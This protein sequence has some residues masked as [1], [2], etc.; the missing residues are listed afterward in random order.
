[1]A[2]DCS[3]KKP[4]AVLLRLGIFVP[5]LELL[6]LFWDLGIFEK[7][8]K[9]V[10]ELFYFILQIIFGSVFNIYHDIPIFCCTTTYWYC[11]KDFWSCI[12][13]SPDPDSYSCTANLS[14]TH[15]S[16]NIKNRYWTDIYHAHP[17][18]KLHK[19]NEKVQ[20]P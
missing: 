16:E 11:S 14:F 9:C 19:L 7:V 8:W 10:K 12:C 15:T 3:G 17:G 6:T 13:E 1:M 2:F 5:R 20:M 18:K 4:R